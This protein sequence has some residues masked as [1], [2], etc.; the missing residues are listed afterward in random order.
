[1]LDFYQLVLTA[2]AVLQPTQLHCATSRRRCEP[3]AHRCSPLPHSI[4]WT[5]IH[6]RVTSLQHHLHLSLAHLH[7]CLVRPWINAPRST[8]PPIDSSS[9]AARIAPPASR[10]SPVNPR[11]SARTP[12][13]PWPHPPPPCASALPLESRSRAPLFRSRAAHHQLTAAASHTRPAASC[14]AWPTAPPCGAQ[15]HSSAS[16]PCAEPLQRLPLEL[17]TA[18][19]AQLPPAPLPLCSGSSAGSSTHYRSTPSGTTAKGISSGA[20]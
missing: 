8:L 5:K 11:P 17:A 7:P 2:L 12:P 18:A 4:W 19:P 20:T 3:S 15:N 13:G 6:C 9:H 1:V 10:H 14:P 16:L